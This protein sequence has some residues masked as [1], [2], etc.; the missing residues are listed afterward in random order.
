MDNFA[1]PY[2][3]SNKLYIFKMMIIL[4][5]LQTNKRSLKFIMLSDRN[6]SPR[7]DISL[8]LGTLS[9]IRAKPS[10]ILFFNFSLWFDPTSARTLNDQWNVLSCRKQL[11]MEYVGFLENF[12]YLII[13]KIAYRSRILVSWEFAFQ[14][15]TNLDN[16]SIYVYNKMKHKT[17]HSVRAIPKS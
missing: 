14:V 2:D 1:E 6:K 10:L 8:N 9:W 13:L 15:Y 12:N 11:F 17:Y 5:S 4:A 7:V 3:D 16:G